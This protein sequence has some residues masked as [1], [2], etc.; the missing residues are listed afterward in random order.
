MCIRQPVTLG[1]SFESGTRSNWTTSKIRC[2]VPVGVPVFSRCRFPGES[3]SSWLLQTSDWKLNLKHQLPVKDVYSSPYCQLFF[4]PCSR[5]LNLTVTL[6]HWNVYL[7][8]HK[9]L[10][11][12]SKNFYKR[13]TSEAF[14]HTYLCVHGETVIPA[15]FG[16]P[17]D[18]MR[19][20]N[21]DRREMPY[22]HWKHWK[23]GSS[24]L[25]CQDSPTKS[26]SDE[27]SHA[28]YPCWL[29]TSPKHKHQRSFLP[30]PSNHKES[31]SVYSLNGAVRTPVL[32]GLRWQISSI[33]S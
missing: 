4:W 32:W 25:F 20:G 19:A 7:C 28:T 3:N 30:T 22:L 14:Q 23:L 6:I 24:R 10:T 26:Q 29:Q 16:P 21:H 12:T 15:R 9:N 31:I 18:T 13:R 2:F 17:C 27:A 33:P 11:S 8:W 1:G 5:Y